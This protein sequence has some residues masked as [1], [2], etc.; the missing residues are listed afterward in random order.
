MP[1]AG[2][3]PGSV[4]DT[5]KL[6]RDLSI[7]D[8]QLTVRNRQ[9]SIG[10]V[11]SN[12]RPEDNE[13]KGK[14]SMSRQ[15]GEVLLLRL[16]MAHLVA[17]F[18]LQ[19]ECWVRQRFQK[20]W[21]SLWLY[22][23][24][25]IAAALGYLM[26]GY[27]KAFWLPVAI[28]VSHVLLDGLKAQGQDNCR[29]FLLDQAG[30]LTIVLACW[31]F[32]AREN[33]VMLS[34]FILFLSSNKKFWVL[35]FFYFCSIWPAGFWIGK[36][37][38]VWQREFDGSDVQGL[39]KAGLWIGCM[40]RVLILTFVLLNRF[41]AIGFLIAAKSIFR[42]G[43][44]HLPERRKEAEYILIGTMISFTIAIGLGILGRLAL[45]YPLMQ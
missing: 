18:L 4:K 36:I 30:H 37:T 2:Q 15:V 19:R 38:Q 33:V 25:G 44:I 23:H 20:K 3:W 41:D 12:Q 32:L 14:K 6:S 24:S 45:H 28:F 29:A 17:D 39:A 9:Q 21:A 43:E 10:Y 8:E 26:A 34:G 31:I 22:A 7:S 1:A 13:D 27:W 42:F 11:V 5:R 40:E 35:L 16:L